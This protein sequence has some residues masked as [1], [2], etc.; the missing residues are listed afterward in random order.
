M[1][2]A[3]AP[4]DERY[5]KETFHYGEAPSLFVQAY[6]HLLPQTCR[7]ADLGSGEGRNAVWLASQGHRVWAVDG[8]SAGLD[9][10][11]VL[12]QLHGVEVHLVHSD[13]FAWQ[14]EEPLDAVLASFLHVPPTRRPDLFAHL[15]TIV[16]PGGFVLGEWFRPEQRHLNLPSG[17]PP[18]V[19]FLPSHE[20]IAHYFSSPLVLE[21]ANPFLEEGGGHFGQAAVIRLMWQST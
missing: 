8:S 6:A 20:E 13:L 11:S 18:D 14:P 17:G 12:A 9:K 4:W 5:M 1:N 3:F 7:I 10:T 2:P 15:K 19:S 21:E 16:R